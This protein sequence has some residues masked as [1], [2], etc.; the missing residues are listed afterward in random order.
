MLLCKSEWCLKLYHKA[1]LNSLLKGQSALGF[2]LTHIPKCWFGFCVE[3]FPPHTQYVFLLLYYS[4]CFAQSSSGKWLYP[5]LWFV[6][7]MW[8]VGGKMGKTPLASNN[9]TSLLCPVPTGCRGWVSWAGGA[10][11]AGI[12]LQVFHWEVTEAALNTISSISSVRC[13]VGRKV[14][15]QICWH[16]G[17]ASDLLLTSQKAK[18]IRPARNVSLRSKKAQATLVRWARA[19][20]ESPTR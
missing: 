6:G 12:A 5:E 4:S 14:W 17:N 1:E 9:V 13:G 20:P 2:L 3:I 7:K 11:G 15:L 18:H 16:H 19:L 8:C 10:T